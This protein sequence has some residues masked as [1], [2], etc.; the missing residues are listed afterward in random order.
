[1]EIGNL[2][3]KKGKVFLK[4]WK[5]EIESPSGTITGMCIAIIKD[6]TPLSS[7]DF[8]SAPLCVESF[9]FAHDI[10]SVEFGVQG[11]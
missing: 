2:F 4:S 1:M 6:V 9:L 7:L 3:G 11:N 5:I 10:A 8:S